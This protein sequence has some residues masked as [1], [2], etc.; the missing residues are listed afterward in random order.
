MVLEDR[1]FQMISNVAREEI[2]ACVYTCRRFGVG[3]YKCFVRGRRTC[4][5]EVREKESW[6]GLRGAKGGKGDTEPGT[7][8]R[9][10]EREREREG[11][12]SSDQARARVYEPRVRSLVYVYSCRFACVWG[13]CDSSCGRK[14]E[15]CVPAAGSSTY[16]TSG[17]GDR[18]IDSRERATSRV[19]AYL[20]LPLLLKGKL[21]GRK[22]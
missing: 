7:K 17:G 22:E 12:S 3:K 11:G 5:F 6:K 10:R 13:S 19:V 15:S 21:E 18:Y 16:T 2:R 9:E 14:R 1:S 4:A 20:F 8:G